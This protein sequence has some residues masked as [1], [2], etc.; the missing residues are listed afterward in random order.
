MDYTI[1][2]IDNYATGVDLARRAQMATMLWASWSGAGFMG[3]VWAGKRLPSID[4]RLQKIME[5]PGTKRR[6]EIEEVVD[7]MNLIARR[8]GLP[9]PRPRA[10]KDMH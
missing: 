2:E 8:A 4:R 6:S 3:H 7:R 9:K 10:R 1:R 5:R